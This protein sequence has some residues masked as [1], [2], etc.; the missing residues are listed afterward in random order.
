[1]WTPQT[2]LPRHKINCG[3]RESALPAGTAFDHLKVERK[4]SAVSFIDWLNGWCGM[5]LAGIQDLELTTTETNRARFA[6]T[7]RPKTQQ[8]IR[9]TRRQPKARANLPQHPAESA[10][11]AEGRGACRTLRRKRTGPR[12]QTCR[13]EDQCSRLG[14][15]IQ[16]DTRSTAAGVGRIAGGKVF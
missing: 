1:M 13:V 8:P 10:R 4:A 11:R 6:R 9:R 5:A 12:T 7:C 3:E 16:R 2:R 14:F 15:I